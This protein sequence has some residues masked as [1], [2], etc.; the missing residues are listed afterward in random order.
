VAELVARGT[1]RDATEP[2]VRHGPRIIVSNDSGR[3]N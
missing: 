3:L 1:E 2:G